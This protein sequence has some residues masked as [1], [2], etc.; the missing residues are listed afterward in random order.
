MSNIGLYKALDAVGIGYEKT[1]VGDKYVAECMRQ[2]GHLIGGEQSGHI[3]FGKYANTGDGLLT[4]IKI[5]QVMFDQKKTLG[6]LA[7]A[8]HVYPQ[9][10]TNVVV[11]DKKA[12]LDDP[13]VKAAEAAVAESLGSASSCARA[14]PSRCCASWSRRPPRRSAPRRCRR[15]LRRCAHRDILSG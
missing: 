14:A 3:I 7:S 4:A 12:T 11:D 1:P 8:V 9:L 13:A 15:S 5:M 6:E 2:N 10:L